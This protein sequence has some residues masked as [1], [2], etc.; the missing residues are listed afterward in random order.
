MS[1]AELRKVSVLR[2]GIAAV[3]LL[4][5]AGQAQAQTANVT[6]ENVAV[7]NLLS[8]FLNLNATPVGQQ[9]LQ[10][11]LSQSVAINQNASSVALL[12]N[13]LSTPALAALAIS[14]ENSL[15]KASNAVTGLSK[16]YG[17]AANLAGGLPTQ[18]TTAWAMFNGQQP[19]GGFGS[20]LGAAYVNGVGSNGAAVSLPN[21]INLL[22]A[23]NTQTVNNLA[24]SDSQ[25][26]K[27]YFANGTID[28]TTPAVAPA[29]YTL[30][31]ANGLPNKKNSVYDTAFG[32]SNTQSGQNALGN[33]H[34]YQT[35]PVNNYNFTLY[36]STVKSPS[37]ASGA[38]TPSTNPAFPSSHEA[39]AMTDSLLLGMM[40]PQLYQSMLLRA[41]EMGESRIVIGVHYPTDIIASRAFV[42]FDVAN[43]LGNPS[44][45]NNAAVTGTA[46]NLPSLF[47]SA[48]TELRSQLTQAAA[49]AG[50]GTSLATCATSS[51]NVNPYAPS[52]TNTAVYDARM[53]YGLPTLSYAQAP[54]E[55]APAAGPDASILLATVYGGSSAAAQALASSV[56]GAL[57]GNLSTATIN[58][59]IVNTES[60]ALAAFYGTP[61]S[62]WSRVDLYDAAGYFQ[63]ITGNLTLAPTDVVNTN[64]TIASGGG[65]AGH[66]TINGGLT[67]GGGGSLLSTGSP[68]TMTVNGPVSFQ[69]GSSYQ[70]AIGAPGTSDLIAA[71]GK[72]T[73]S[74]GTVSVLPSS[75]F[76]GRLGN[77]TILT[78]GG[79]LSG[80]FAGVLTPFGSNYYPFVGASLSYSSTAAQL[81][82]G[83][84]T[85]FAAASATANQAAAGNALDALPISNSLLQAAS[86]LN[87]QTAPPALAALSGDIYGSIASVMQ[88]QGA[89]VRDVIGSRI[90]QAIGPEGGPQLAALGPV[91]APVMPGSA[92]VIW[93]Q[94]LGA[95]GSLDSAGNATGIDR[96]AA[97][98]L[99]GVD[100]PLWDDWRG[101]LASGFDQD[102]FNSTGTASHASMTGAHLAGYVGRRFGAVGVD[103][104]A[105]NT[106]YSG[107]ANRTVAFPGFT[108]SDSGGIGGTVTQTFG[109]VTL[110]QPVPQVL[111]GLLAQPFIGVAYAHVDSNGFGE[112]GGA[113]ALRVNASTLDDVYTTL[114]ARAAVPFELAGVP[115]KADG[116]AGWQHT[117][118]TVVPSVSLA[119]ANGAGPFTAQGVPLARDTAVVG[120]GLRYD[121]SPSLSFALGYTGRLASGVTDN[122]VDG[123]LTLRF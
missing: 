30:P 23:A 71:T 6:P 27:F 50:C 122:Q 2:G 36:D 52:A 51:T 85:P 118:G 92:A 33:S 41:S 17:V 68:G 37:S 78:A 56:G 67:V 24:S 95:W 13:N 34:P 40:V 35:A 75:G 60:Q 3:A 121:A 5:F 80:Q 55:Q 105:S 97:G 113:A 91:A 25:V 64:V 76:S 46:V 109:E 49:T 83:K 82:I 8:P 108:D 31:T 45:I 57:Y 69:A 70:V 79:G 98:Y 32:V 4:I 63:G 39:Y 9:T 16:T 12:N 10:A 59:I 19:V 58:Q 120:A 123:T 88:Q 74:G 1:V 104:V 20:I 102:W 28:A 7:F 48:A 89:V 99:I 29:G 112:T 62:Y 11:S 47:A 115:L 61:L 72:A 114:G 73:L 66:A 117:F 21:T 103:F 43:L 81:T 18:N 14:D 65:L 44:Y 54:Q 86:L 84:G 77:Y 110:H 22:V 53:T 96:S 38:P 101:G 111:P 93:Q 106:W 116:M 100:A 107:T 87:Y 119:F 90:R 15:T 94:A 26:S 42:A